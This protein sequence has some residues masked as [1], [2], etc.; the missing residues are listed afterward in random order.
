MRSEIARFQ[1]IP[2]LKCYVVDDNGF[3]MIMTDLEFLQV[4]ATRLC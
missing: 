2:A 3:G 1:L 4:I